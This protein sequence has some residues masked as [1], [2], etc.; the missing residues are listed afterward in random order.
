MAANTSVVLLPQLVLMSGQELQT[1]DIGAA[2]I[3]FVIYVLISVVMSIAGL[4]YLI[5]IKVD[6]DV[7]F[8][9]EMI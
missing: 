5:R 4:V 6:K 1:E 3:G 9:R 7:V 2:S 8:G